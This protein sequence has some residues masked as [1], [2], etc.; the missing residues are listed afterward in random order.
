MKVFHRHLYLAL[1]F[2]VGRDQK[3]CKGSV[4]AS[5]FEYIV[6]G[7]TLTSSVATQLFCKLY[8]VLLL[9]NVACVCMGKN[10]STN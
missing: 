9:G 2:R 1:L 4:A 7:I 8:R 6:L 10:T 5:S 3:K